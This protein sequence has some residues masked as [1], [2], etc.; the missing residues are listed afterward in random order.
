M[1]LP[2]ILTLAIIFSLS[3]NQNLAEAGRDRENIRTEL[4]RALEQA[5]LGNSEQAGRA[6]RGEDQWTLPGVP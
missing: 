2:L 6:A 5:R 1:I 4:F 3:V